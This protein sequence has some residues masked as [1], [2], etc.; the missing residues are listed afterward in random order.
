MPIP[1]PKNHTPK[2]QKNEVTRRRTYRGPE[3][4]PHADGQLHGGEKEVPHAHI[5]GDE[6]ASGGDQPRDR[7]GLS[8]GISGDEGRNELLAEHERL[9]LKRRIDDPKE[10]EDDLQNALRPDEIYA[11]DPNCPSCFARC[12]EGIH[13]EG[14]AGHIF[15][16]SLSGEGLSL[17]LPSVLHQGDKVMRLLRWVDLGGKL[18]MSGALRVDQD[19]PGMH[20][21]VA[22]AR[23]CDLLRERQR[24]PGTFLC[25]LNLCDGA[26]QADERCAEMIQPGPDDAG[27][28]RVGSV[29]TK[30]TCTSC[31]STAGIP[32]MDDAARYILSGHRSGQCV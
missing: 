12:R 9:V 14:V 5:G 2:A 10:P 17:R 18:Q 7:F 32:A 25:L 3:E 24:D 31:R 4:Q 15:A 21:R 28:S 1:S 6:V 20:H 13:C 29:V 26:G 22:R 11:A 27:V 23:F 30:T 19:V 8:T 16:T